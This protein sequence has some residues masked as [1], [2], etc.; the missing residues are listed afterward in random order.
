M[1]FAL[2]AAPAWITA[3]WRSGEIESPPAAAPH[4]HR[5]I[6]LQ[7]GFHPSQRPPERGIGDRPVRR[8]DHDHQAVAPEPAEVLV[9]Q[10]PRVNGL[11]AGRLPSGPGQRLL[12]TRRADAEADGDH[13]PR[14]RDGREVRRGPAAQPPDGAR[15]AADLVAHPET[16]RRGLGLSASSEMLCAPYLSLVRCA[17]SLAKR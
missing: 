1:S 8:V 5:R 15:A 14:R 16:G 3:V 9:D 12:D 2:R 17:R 7:L 10:L 4:R 6:A 11:R 13:E